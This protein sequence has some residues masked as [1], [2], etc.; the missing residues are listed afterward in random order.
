M[1]NLSNPLATGKKL[2]PSTMQGRFQ[3]HQRWQTWK[4][5]SGFK[6]LDITRARPDLFSQFFLRQFTPFPQQGDVFTESRPMRAA[7]GFARW[8]RL[9]LAKRGDTQHEALHRVEVRLV[10]GGRSFLSRQALTKTGVLPKEKQLFL[11]DLPV[12][13]VLV[14]AGCHRLKR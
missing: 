8:H 10:S 2:L 5:F 1:K 11:K 3:M 6:T 14:I 12:C 7:F 4:V 9:M 13:C